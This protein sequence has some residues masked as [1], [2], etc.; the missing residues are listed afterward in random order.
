MAYSEQCAFYFFPPLVNFKSNN[1]EPVRSLPW[2]SSFYFPIKYW[3]VCLQTTGHFQQGVHYHVIVSDF[4]NSGV[5]K[6]QYGKQ[7]GTGIDNWVFSHQ[8]LY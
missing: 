8:A 7:S 1:Y 3:S 2:S 6:T 4:G 5:K